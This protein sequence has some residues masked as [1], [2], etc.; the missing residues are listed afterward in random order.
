MLPPGDCLPT[1]GEKLRMLPKLLSN[2]PRAAGRTM[3]SL[4]VWDK[5]AARIGTRYIYL[6][7]GHRG[8]GSATAGKVGLPDGHEAIRTNS[9]Q[10]SE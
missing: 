3:R 6:K 10:L 9:K 7:G 5:E 4:G 8:A 2:G 1:L